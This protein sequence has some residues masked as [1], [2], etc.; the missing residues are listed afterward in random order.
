M[1]I[2][3]CT[4][5]GEDVT[6]PK[7]FSFNGGRACRKHQEVQDS[8]QERQKEQAKKLDKALALQSQ[9]K[10]PAWQKT[11]ALALKCRCFSC[12]STAVKKEE[13]ADAMLVSMAKAKKNAEPSESLWDPNSP[14]HSRVREQLGINLGETPLIVDRYDVSTFSDAKLMAL[15][16]GDLAIRDVMRFTKLALL[17]SNCAANFGL[18]QEKPSLEALMTLAPVAQLLIDDLADKL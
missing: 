2:F 11:P 1:S 3:K 16:R 12:K 17:C 10:I 8:A 4:V 9:P 14:L 7:S 5:C 13:W 18:V 15:A 6:R